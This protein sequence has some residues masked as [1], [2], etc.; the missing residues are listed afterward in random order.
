MALAKLL[1]HLRTNTTIN[2]D[3]LT[4]IVEDVQNYDI[5]DLRFMTKV[6][7]LKD[8]TK[9]PHENAENNLVDIRFIKYTTDETSDFHELHARMTVLFMK[10]RKTFRMELFGT[11]SAKFKNECYIAKLQEYLYTFMA[12]SIETNGKFKEFREISF[13]D[14]LSSYYRKTPGWETVNLMDFTWIDRDETPTIN[15][16]TNGLL[17]HRSI[18]DVEEPEE[19]DGS[20]LTVPVTYGSSTKEI[21]SNITKV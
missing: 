16:I 19:D 5:R 20:D 3:I 6:M 12:R 14:T 4:P 13:P 2:V 7:T 11:I 15:K 17:D 18:C 21:P 8:I 1:L 9:F 10:G